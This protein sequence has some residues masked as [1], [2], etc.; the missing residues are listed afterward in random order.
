MVALKKKAAVNFQHL[1]FDEIGK[2]KRGD[3]ESHHTGPTL[4]TDC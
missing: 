3:Q 4:K 1:S 2:V